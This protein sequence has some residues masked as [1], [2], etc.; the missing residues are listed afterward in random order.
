MA[1]PAFL[2]HLGWK[3]RRF[4][5]TPL[6][7]IYLRKWCDLLHIP[8]KGVFSRNEPKPRCHS[9]CIINLH[10]WCAV[11]GDCRHIRIFR[12]YRTPTASRMGGGD[13]R[14]EKFLQEPQAVPVGGEREMRI[15]LPSLVEGKEQRHEPR[16]RHGHVT[17]D[18][19][20]NERVVKNYFSLSITWTCTVCERTTG[21]A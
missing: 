14:K 9:P 18:V 4:Q 12:L 21:H 8:I 7:N 11:G 16:F 15:L 10:T 5:D 6:S 20:Q 17:D 19:H 13:A 3:K 2:R 1:A